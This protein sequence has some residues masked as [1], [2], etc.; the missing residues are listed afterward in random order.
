MKLSRFYVQLLPIHF[1]QTMDIS[2]FESQAYVFD[3]KA[4]SWNILYKIDQ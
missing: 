3:L 4:L 2:L 1:K